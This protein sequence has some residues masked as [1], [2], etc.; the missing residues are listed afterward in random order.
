[1]SFV[2]VDTERALAILKRIDAAAEE[3]LGYQQAAQ[4]LA[5]EIHSCWSGPSGATVHEKA[6][7]VKINQGKIANKILAASAEAKRKLEQMEEADD[8]LASAIGNHSSGG[9]RRG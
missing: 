9:G 8:A 1:M 2:H 3:Y 7:L 4:A 6:I 5:D